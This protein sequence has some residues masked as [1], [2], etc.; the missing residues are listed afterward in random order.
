MSEQFD[1]LTIEHLEA[2]WAKLPHPPRPDAYLMNWSAW[3]KARR[4]LKERAIPV[5]Y[6][7]VGYHRWRRYV[8]G[9]E[10]ILD[11]YIVGD[12]IY[13]VTKPP[14]SLGLKLSPPVIRK[15]SIW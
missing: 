13:E 6:R 3:C 9:V 10:I 14:F 4:V 15:L 11:R 2:A 1:K 7:A 8:T 5:E 12:E